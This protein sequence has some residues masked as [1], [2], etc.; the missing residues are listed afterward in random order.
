M[1][2][3]CKQSPSKAFI[4][5]TESGMLH[6]LKKECPDKQFI[7]VPISNCVCNEC[8]YMKMNTLEKLLACMENLNPRVELSKEIIEKARQPIERMLAICIMIKVFLIK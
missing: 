4:I 8:K 6:R 3:Y 1:V 7:S 5:V 2:D